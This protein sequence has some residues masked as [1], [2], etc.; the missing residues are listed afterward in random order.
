MS[1]STSGALM[2]AAHTTSSAGMEVPLASV[3]P[4]GVTSMTARR[5]MDAHA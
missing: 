5:G 2:P 1:L 4:F 3:T